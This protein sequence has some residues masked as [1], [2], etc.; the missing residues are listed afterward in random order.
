MCF[1]EARG[2]TGNAAGRLS[3]NCGQATDLAVATVDAAR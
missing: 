2:W 1:A 3:W